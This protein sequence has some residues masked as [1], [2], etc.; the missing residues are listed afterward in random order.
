MHPKKKYTLSQRLRVTDQTLKKTSWRRY[1]NLLSIVLEDYPSD[2]SAQVLGFVKSRDFGCLLRWADTFGGAVHATAEEAFSAY[3][4]TS[5][6][7]KYPYPAAELK[8]QARQAATDKFHASENRC[9]K[10]NLKFH[11]R[12]IGRWDPDADVHKRM[13]DWI[14]YIIGF[15]P[16]LPAIY[17]ECG[18]GPGASLGVHGQNTNLA[19]KLLSK[20]WS[21]TASALPYAVS[22]LAQDQ[23][24]WELL[25]PDVNRPVCFDFPL[26]AKAVGDKVRLVH[27]N[28]IVFV[29]KTTLVDRTI[30]VEPLLN[31]YVQKGVDQFMRRRLKRIGLDLS[32]QTVNQERARQGSIPGQLDPFVTI[33]LS[34]ASDSISIE[35]VKRLL[36]PEWFELLN[37]L[38][39]KKY[40]LDGVEH[41]YEKFVSMGNG[42]CFPLETLIFA[43]ACHVSSPGDFVVYGDDIIVRQSKAVEVLRIL[44]RLGFRHNPDKTFLQGPFRESCG[45]DWF[46]GR[47][48]R[49]LTLDYAL[50]SFESI[51]KFHNMSLRKPLWASYFAKVRKY[52]ID[53]V[54]PSVRL[55]RPFVGTVD[56]AFEVPLDV[57]QASP[58]SRWDRNI[59]TWSWCELVRSSCRDTGVESDER[60]NTVLTMGALRGSLSQC[61]FASRRKTSRTI[62]RLSYAG[63]ISTWTPPVHSLPV[64]RLMTLFYLNQMVM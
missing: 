20:R 36:P 59:Q 64:S 15:Q 39:A 8:H 45:A 26:F 51:A 1:V 23:H 13:S 7:K 11:R 43:S 19:R 17:Q 24:V 12:N 50:D 55:C 37:A 41:T 57:F 30:A 62:R 2:V 46:A 48:I 25:N 9:R 10:Y 32:D 52:L 31:G 21:C 58:F 40:E 34:A 56:S 4:L 54:P 16:D 6:I 5:L 35:V 14:A 29:P 28:N 3:Q 63:S 18:F 42:F 47:E 44:R 33:D 61:P 60:F 38:R 27:N 22:A 53:E 49:P